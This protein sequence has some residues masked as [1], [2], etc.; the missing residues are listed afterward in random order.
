MCKQNREFEG[1]LL[2]HCE[3]AGAL[4]DVFFNQFGLSWVLPRQVIDLY[5]CPWTVGT[6]Q[7]VVVWKMVLAYLLWCLWKEKNEKVLRTVR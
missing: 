6:A 5:V 3:V 4:W 2:L 1:H 7:S